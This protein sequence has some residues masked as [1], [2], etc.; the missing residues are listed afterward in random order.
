M[1]KKGIDLLMKSISN[2]KRRE[3]EK[4]SYYAQEENGNEQKRSFKIV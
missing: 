1:C 3:V 2:C 4:R